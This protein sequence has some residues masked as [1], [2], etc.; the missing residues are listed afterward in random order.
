M[1]RSCAIVGRSGAIMNPSV[2]IAKVPSARKYDG[3]SET[4]AADVGDDGS[5]DARGRSSEDIG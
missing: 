2:P 1:L 5:D 4:L 3:R